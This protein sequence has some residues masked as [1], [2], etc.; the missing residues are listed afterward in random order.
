MTTENDLLDAILAAE[1]PAYDPAAHVIA[2]ALA[3]EL[4]LS[5]HAALS[6]M[7]RMARENPALELIEV[8]VENGNIAIALVRK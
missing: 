7:K 3:R 1:P 8:R 4:G 6:R 2:K 5:E